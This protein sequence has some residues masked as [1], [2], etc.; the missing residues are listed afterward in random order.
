MLTNNEIK[1]IIKLIR[2]L[3][4][5]GILLKGTVGKTIRQEGGFSDFLRSSVLSMAAVLPLMKNVYTP[6]SKSVLI[7][8]GLAKAVSVADATIQK[9]IFGSGTA[10]FKI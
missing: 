10:A 3:E 8:L 7:P 1:D 2:S 6:L 4:N 5:R 9:K